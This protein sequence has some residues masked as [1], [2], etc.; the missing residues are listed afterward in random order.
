MPKCELV[1]VYSFGLPVRPGDPAKDDERY[2]PKNDETIAQVLGTKK[3][4][5]FQKGPKTFSKF[6]QFLFPIKQPAAI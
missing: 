6:E 4:E 5:K 3:F 1:L 2:R